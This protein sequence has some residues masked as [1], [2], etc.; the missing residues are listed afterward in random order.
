LVGFTDFDWA[1]DPDDRKSTVGYMFTPHSGPITWAFKKQ[2][3]ISLSS[4]KAKYCGIVEASKQ[5][6]WLR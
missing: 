1:S 4:T 5:A 6:L 2:S 3:E